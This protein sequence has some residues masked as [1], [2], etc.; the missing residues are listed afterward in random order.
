MTYNLS[1]LPEVE[2]DVIAGYVWYQ[3]KSPG[4]GEDEKIPHSEL[5]TP[6]LLYNFSQRPHQELDVLEAAGLPHETDSPDLSLQRS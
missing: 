2:E 5:R 3:G 6:H 1:F 4:F